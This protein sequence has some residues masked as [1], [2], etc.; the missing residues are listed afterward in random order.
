MTENELVGWY[1]Q[2]NGHD[3]EQTLGDGKDR[4]AQHAAVHG[5]AELDLTTTTTRMNKPKEARFKER[6]SDWLILSLIEKLS[7]NYYYYFRNEETESQSSYVFYYFL[8]QIT[9]LVHGS[10]E[11]QR[12]INPFSLPLTISPAYDNTFCLI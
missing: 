12:A 7:D 8:S 4:E 2:L 5:V 11:I 3:F 9:Q 10:G 6:S 1:H